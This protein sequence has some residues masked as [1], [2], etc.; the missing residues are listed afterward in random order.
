MSLLNNH[1]IWKETNNE[2][3]SVFHFHRKY[4][5]GDPIKNLKQ[6]AADQ[7]PHHVRSYGDKATDSQLSGL[8]E[9]FFGSTD[10]SGPAYVHWYHLNRRVDFPSSQLAP[11]SNPLLAI[12]RF[13]LYQILPTLWQSEG[14]NPEQ[15]NENSDSLLVLAIM[16][17]N[18]ELIQTLLTLGAD[19]NRQLTYGEYGSALAAAVYSSS[20]LRNQYKIIKILLDAGAD[21][22]AELHVGKY[23]TAL[24]AAE[25]RGND[26]IIHLLLEHGAVQKGTSSPPTPAESIEA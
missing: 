21:V 5:A 9:K 15:V 8:L 25:A 16:S 10:K 14:I 6:Y 11:C 1:E 12:C 26:E 24:D 13:G 20:F 18:V 19:V 7:W 17:G 2:E 4:N 23:S 3:G 22:N